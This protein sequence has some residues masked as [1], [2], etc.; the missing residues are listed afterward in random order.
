M[1][2]HLADLTV[3]V[4]MPTVLPTPRE[5]PTMLCACHRNGVPC[6]V[7]N[8]SRALNIPVMKMRLDQSSWELLKKNA[9]AK[10]AVKPVLNEDIDFQMY[11]QFAIE[12]LWISTRRWCTLRVCMPQSN[13]LY[14]LSPTVKHVVLSRQEHPK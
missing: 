4:H 7:G 13:T 12:C 9:G 3:Y 5:R 14:V 2:V 1:A 11:A 10:C 8:L 6:R